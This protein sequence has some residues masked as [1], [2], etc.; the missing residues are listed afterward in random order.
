VLGIPFSHYLMSVPFVSV[1]AMRNSK[2]I[3]GYHL[4][5]SIVDH[6]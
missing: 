2:S 1:F 6:T 3:I 4:L 5:Y